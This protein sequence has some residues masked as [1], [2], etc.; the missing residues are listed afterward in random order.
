MSTKM[1]DRMMRKPDFGQR[2]IYDKAMQASLGRNDRDTASWLGR[3]KYKAGSFNGTKS[4]AGTKAFKTDAF[5]GAGTQ[6]R[7][8]SQTFSGADKTASYADSTFDTKAS[9][10]ATKEAREGR[11]VFSGAGDQF[12][13][14]SNRAAL[15]SQK[16]NEGPKF[17]ELEEYTRAPAYGEDQVR[18]LMGRD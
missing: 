7:M 6:S 15:K 1:Q 3:Q 10:F 13:T 17:I 4:F 12:K 2:S 11:Q 8:G 5:S 18:K 9:G 14:F 16:K